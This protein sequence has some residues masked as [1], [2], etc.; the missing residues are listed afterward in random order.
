VTVDEGCAGLSKAAQALSS[1]IRGIVTESVAKDLVA[2]YFN[3]EGPFAGT[4]F[5]L[6]GANPENE[7]CT[8]D[9]LA[10]SFLGIEWWPSAVRRLLGRDA[11]RFSAMLE[12]IEPGVDL[13]HPDAADA[14]HEAEV[15]WEKLKGIPGI[16]WVT[17]CK[18]LA[19]K[20]PRL[21]PVADTVVLTALAPPE[22]RY[23]VTLR[24]CLECA[25][26]RQQI[27]DLRPANAESVSL[28][29]LLDAAVWIRYSKRKS[30]KKTR[31]RLGIK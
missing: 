12:R 8:D 15:M 16:D 30:A 3:P 4:S 2:A 19:R 11:A 17:A 1:Q 26:R 14:L 23:W 22:H 6:L 24:E 21:V 5:D 9:L 29:R 18:L 7:I 20:R 10:V 27:E 13:W 31:Q 28:L 25:D